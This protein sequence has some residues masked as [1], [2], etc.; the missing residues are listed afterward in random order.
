MDETWPGSA[1]LFI[2]LDRGAGPRRGIESALRQ[3][4]RTGRLHTG[5]VLPSS[6]ALATDLGVARGTVSAA[7]GQ[8]AAE[9]YLIARQGA[10]S[11]V[12]WVPP[13]AE[14]RP[15]PPAR[16]GPR[17]ELRPGQPDP[18]SFPRAAWARAA[19]QV[20]REFPA[21]ALGYGDPWGR[22]EL[23]EA[24]SEYLGRARGV[25]ASD[26]PLLIC[27]GFSQALTVLC[28][29]LRAAG[30]RRLG[31]EDPCSPR[32]R[33]AARECGL[34]V[35]ALRCDEHGLRTGLLDAARV[36]AVLAT[37]AHQHPLGVTMPVARRGAL[38]DWA[39][40]TG[41][42][43]IEDDYDGEFR[44][45]RH[46]V[47]AVQQLDPARVAYVGS[48]SKT[49]APGL[50]LGWLT[51]PPAIES[52][53]LA[54]RDRLDRGSS[55]FGQLILARLIA[56][57]ELDRHVRRMRTGYRRR[58]DQFL[59]VAADRFP[60]ASVSGIAAGLHAVL[61]WPPN[62]PGT[63]E[64]RIAALAARHGLALHTLHRYWHDPEGAPG[65]IVVGYG[66]PP[67]HA[68]QAT[69]GAFADFLTDL[70]AGR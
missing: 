16:P 9:G 22:P 32:Y 19:R 18:A 59:E 60:E 24:L 23:R 65:G 2:D 39:R 8:L 30:A 38:V 64:E 67:A 69:L 66:S 34:E 51:V 49:L 10:A 11:R 31:M 53:V 36:D 47:G 42:L 15:A 6:R 63:E 35:V 41:G 37:P 33:E 50:R 28:L 52:G 26:A 46:P 14:R 13:A 56:T 55:V 7:Y 25:L 29:A 4:I 48:A 3:A 58:R 70:R 45:D 62:W 1:D 43:V 27:V 21:E 17:W 12:A 57:G 5:S 40:R 20:Y 68:Y 44:F 54:V 61:S